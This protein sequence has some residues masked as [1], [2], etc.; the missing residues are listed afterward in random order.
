MITAEVWNIHGFQSSFMFIKHIIEKRKL[1]GTLV[2]LYVFTETMALEETPPLPLYDLVA[3]V[4][5]TISSDSG[6]GRPSGGVAAYALQRPHSTVP[7]QS[8]MLPCPLR[9]CVAIGLGDSGSAP[10]LALVAYYRRPD[11]PADAS[12]YF[13]TLSK[14]ASLLH[15]SSHHVVALGDANAHL[16]EDKSW[17][18]H[19]GDEEGQA[20]SHHTSAW[21][22]RLLPASVLK[23]TFRSPQGATST[24]D[25][26]AAHYQAALHTESS[27]SPEH[28]PRWSLPLTTHVR[29]Q[30]HTDDAASGALAILAAT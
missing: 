5:A 25:H 14:I 16:A 27:G 17:S 26:A 4:K 12:N 28:R 24:V 29:S 3:V 13:T 21:G 15:A 1:E 18:S 30:R 8:L 2:H 11:G 7:V 19:R 9:D 10:L 20:W 22:Y 23:W 6:R